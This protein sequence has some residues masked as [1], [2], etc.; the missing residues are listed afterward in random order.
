VHFEYKQSNA[1][2]MV[3]N[4]GLCYMADSEA[5]G[6]FFSEEE[7]GSGWLDADRHNSAEVSAVS[8]GWRLVIEQHNTYAFPSP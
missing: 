8:N 7:P 6:S 1:A 3:A 4:R 2:K 5:E